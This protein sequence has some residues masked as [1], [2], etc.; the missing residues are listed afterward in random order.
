MNIVVG[1]IVENT[2]QA[3]KNNDAKML[4]RMDKKLE[5]NLVRFGLVSLRRCFV[6]GWVKLMALLKK[7][8][9]KVI[10]ILLLV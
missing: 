10:R 1:V 6:F 4:A 3:A 9:A 8:D 2:L 5:R 7:E